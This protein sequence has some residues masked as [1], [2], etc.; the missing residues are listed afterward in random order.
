MVEGIISFIIAN[1]ITSWI[2]SILFTGEN[3]VKLGDKWSLS[4]D[5]IFRP[6]SNK[7]WKTFLIFFIGYCIIFLMIYLFS[8]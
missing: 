2:C 3:C 5:K 8:K 7:R 6:L 4:D 1:L